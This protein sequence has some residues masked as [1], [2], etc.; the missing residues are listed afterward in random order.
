MNIY[1]I[2]SVACFM[3]V[4]LIS[5]AFASM[6]LF[7]KKFMPYHAD[8]VGKKWEELD[9]EIRIL[10]LALMRVISGGWLASSVAT[11]IFLY[12]YI[13]IGEAWTPIAI[14][15]TGLSVII[16]TLIATLMVKSRTNAN[17]PVGAAVLVIVLLIAGGLIG[18]LLV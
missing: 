11:G 18:I 2:I 13:R 7:R 14:A 1:M 4:M 15:I 17:P 5:L 3:L 6:Y 12:L 9:P 10:I 16:P 8:A